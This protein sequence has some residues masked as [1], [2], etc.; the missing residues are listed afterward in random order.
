MIA[1]CIYRP[2][3][4]DVCTFNVLLINMLDSLHKN[5]HVFVLGDF[6]V[7]LSPDIETTSAVEEFKI[8]FAHIIYFL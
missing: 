3:W 6:N 4:V 2:P 1:G 8:Y 5:H 7:D